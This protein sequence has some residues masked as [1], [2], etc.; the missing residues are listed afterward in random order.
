MILS[1]SVL[2]K[3]LLLF[4]LAIPTVGGGQAPK[5]EDIWK[6]FEFFIG[7]GGVRAMANRAPRLMNASI[8][9]SSTRGSSK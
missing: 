1:L 9:L 6:P 4:F 2:G 5:S 8:G 7:N 3:I